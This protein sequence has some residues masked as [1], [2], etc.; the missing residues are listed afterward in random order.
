MQSD[1]EAVSAAALS[2]PAQDRAALAERLLDSL[3]DRE[4]KE[5]DAAWAEEA[6]HRLQAYD[7]GELKAI[8]EEEVFR[9]LANRK[10]P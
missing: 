9:S 7:R 2:L 3:D 5:I 8:P 6:E 4:Q 1:L 10:K